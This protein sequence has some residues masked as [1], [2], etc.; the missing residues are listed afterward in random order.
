MPP[1]GAPEQVPS[2][3]GADASGISTASA[4]VINA[5]QIVI[6]AIMLE[7]RVD[8]PHHLSQVDLIP[9]SAGAQLPNGIKS[10]QTSSRPIPSAAEA[11]AAKRR[12]YERRMKQKLHVELLVRCLR[13][14]DCC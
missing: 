9:Q 14:G 2:Y 6:A 7:V 13:G 1:Q 5:V 11:E 4:S 8:E 10:E 3:E 12:A